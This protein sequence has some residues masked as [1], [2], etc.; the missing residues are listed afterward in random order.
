MPTGASLNG[1]ALAQTAVTFDMN[2]VTEPTPLPLGCDVTITGTVDAA[3]IARGRLQFDLFITN[4]GA[5]PQEINLWLTATGPTP[6]TR[7]YSNG[8]LPADTTVHR[9]P[10]FFV[11]SNVPTGTY[12]VAFN[13]GDFTKSVICDAV[14]FVIEKLPDG[15]ISVDGTVLFDAGA[16]TTSLA[17]VSPNP[18]ADRTQIAY[19]VATASQVRL[20][21]YDVLGREVAVLVDGAEEAG[22]HRATFDARGLAAGTYVYRLTVGS[23]VQT[24]R[25]TL[26]N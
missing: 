18:F 7:L 20:A 2:V 6:Y 1:R 24:G 12:V 16:T 8:V 5:T 25:M 4:N 21:V 3:S 19:E 17:A 9:R 22:A 10:D 14:S 23:E 15:S 13:V 11:T 26:S